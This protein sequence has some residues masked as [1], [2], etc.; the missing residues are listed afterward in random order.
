MKPTILTPGSE[1]RRMLDLHAMTPQQRWEYAEKLK[2]DM[3]M[4]G[5][6][7]LGGVGPPSPVYMNMPLPIMMAYSAMVDL[8][9][10]DTVTEAEWDKVRTNFDHF[11]ITHDHDANPGVDSGAAIPGGWRKIVEADVT[12]AAA[13]V[14]FT[15]IPSGFRHLMIVGRVRPATDNSQFHMRYNG[16]SGANYDRDNADG[17][18]NTNALASTFFSVLGRPA[19]SGIKNTADYSAV[20]YTLIPNYAEATLFKNHASFGAFRTA[21]AGNIVGHHSGGMWNSTAAINRI[22]FLMSSG[23][24]DADSFIVLYG[25]NQ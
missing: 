14:D 10:G 13:D 3:A 20:F 18:A 8:G 1:Y 2:R 25:V 7:P 15:S 12:V 16:D 17:G 24:I 9:I 11:A 4:R 6:L 22:T 19:T 5:A 21:A 23:N